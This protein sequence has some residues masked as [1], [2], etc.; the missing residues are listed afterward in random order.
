MISR[1]QRPLNV[2]FSKEFLHLR[3]RSF[4]LLLPQRDCAGL[5]PLL[6]ESRLKCRAH[7]YLYSPSDSNPFLLHRSAV[8]AYLGSFSN[9]YFV[10][11]NDDLV[12]LFSKKALESLLNCSL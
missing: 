11:Y 12:D 6:V 4:C 10:I 1:Q 7:F 3:Y 9:Q 2:I 5:F 8:L